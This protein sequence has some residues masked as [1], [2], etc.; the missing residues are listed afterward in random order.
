[1]KCFGSTLHLAFGLKV[2]IYAA[3]PEADTIYLFD[4]LTVM[5]W[6]E[7]WALPMHFFFSENFNS[8]STVLA[9]VS[10]VI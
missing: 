2:C 10:A 6:V 9:Y 1:M 3:T 4:D 7:K 5:V 8:N